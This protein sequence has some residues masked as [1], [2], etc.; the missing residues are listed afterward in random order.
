[1]SASSHYLVVRGDDLVLRVKAVP[2]A[3][4]DAI[5]GALGDRLKIRVAAPPEDG[6]ANAAIRALLARV[7]ATDVRFIELEH[8]ATNPIKVFVIR[9]AA[10]RHGE[11]AAA[12]ETK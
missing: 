3:K 7:L 1:M 8:G 6:Q 2:G 9:N 10:A 11:I 5:A 4:R 12:L